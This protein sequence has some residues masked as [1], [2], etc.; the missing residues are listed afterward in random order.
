[1][2]LVKDYFFS[3]ISG[4]KVHL[5]G[6]LRRGERGDAGATDGGKR[7]IRSPPG[8]SFRYASGLLR[9]NGAAAAAQNVCHGQTEP[10]LS[11]SGGN[12]SR[13][14]GGA[15]VNGV[16]P[17]AG[18]GRGAGGANMILRVSQSILGRNKTA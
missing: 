4:G 11:L 18:G 9:G 12:G 15:D 3:F 10:E 16:P 5:S 7:K 8:F 13:R 2:V 17:S 6:N 1:M 14:F